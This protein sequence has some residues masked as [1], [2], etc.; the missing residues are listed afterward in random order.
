M[1]ALEVKI[2]IRMEDGKQAEFTLKA[3]VENPDIPLP[4]VAVAIERAINEYTRFRAHADIVET[5]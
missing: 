5:E 4:Q 3:K 1:R 2:L